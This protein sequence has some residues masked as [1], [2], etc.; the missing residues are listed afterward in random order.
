MVLV[1]VIGWILDVLV[2]VRLLVVMVVCMR[3]DSLVV[4]WLCFG[5]PI[6]GGLRF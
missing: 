1:R 5:H 4:D 2:V 3:D 6:L